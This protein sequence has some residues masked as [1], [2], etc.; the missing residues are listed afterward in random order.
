MSMS[1][2]NVSVWLSALGVLIGFFTNLIAALK[3]AGIQDE[4]VHDLLVGKR[5]DELI[6][7]IVNKAVSMVK[8]TFPV[9]KT[10]TVGIHESAGAWIRTLTGSGF[11]VGDWAKDL[12]SKIT[13]FQLPSEVSFIKA[14]LAE[15]GFTKSATITEIIARIKELGYELCEPDDAPALRLAYKDQPCGEYLYIAM[16]PIRD[17]DGDLEVFKLNHDVNGVWL[18]S[19]CA[20]PGDTWNPDASFV[21]RSCK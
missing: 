12:L 3:K 7:E 19:A 18:H 4:Q 6:T 13:K 14:T 9:W 10:V 11:K 1:K 2:K 21:F 5:A 17:S 15:L 16:E 8:S 20:N